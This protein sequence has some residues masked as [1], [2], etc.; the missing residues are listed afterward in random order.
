MATLVN[1]WNDWYYDAPP[2]STLVWAKYSL[3]HDPVMVLTCPNGCCIADIRGSHP[4]PNFWI[5]ATQEEKAEGNRAMAEFRAQLEERVAEEIEALVDAG[6][7]S[8]PSSRVL[9]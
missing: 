7:T 1:G 4:N 5:A 3:S 2:V 9:H 8:D 6:M